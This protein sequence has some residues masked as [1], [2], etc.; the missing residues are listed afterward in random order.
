MCQSHENLTYGRGGETKFCRTFFCHLFDQGTKEQKRGSDG[1]CRSHENL[2]YGRGGETK[3]C[4]T[5]FCLLFFQEKEEREVMRTTM[6]VRSSVA[7]WGLLAI[8]SR[9][10]SLGLSP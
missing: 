7:C 1:V 5:F 9:A 2:T 6:A 8:R 3:F 10:S 4:R